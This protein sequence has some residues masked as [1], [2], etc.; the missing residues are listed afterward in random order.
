LLDVIRGEVSVASLFHIEGMLAT[1]ILTLGQRFYLE[2]EKKRL[3]EDT[4]REEANSQESNS[5]KY[6][7][8]TDFE[9]IDI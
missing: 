7:N 4:A 8:G 6:P 1:F 5:Y 9:G 2:A 3:Q